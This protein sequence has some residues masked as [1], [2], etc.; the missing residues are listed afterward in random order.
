MYLR[1][2]FW[3]SIQ[4]CITSRR[5]DVYF[6]ILQQFSM[7]VMVRGMGR[8]GGVVR[9]FYCRWF[10]IGALSKLRFEDINDRYIPVL[11]IMKP[12]TC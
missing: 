6:D 4:I 2:K 8:R 9:S 10:M 12:A 7:L 1:N 3:R 11:L 5:R